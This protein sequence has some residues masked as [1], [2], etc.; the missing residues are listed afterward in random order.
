MAGAAGGGGAAVA[1]AGTGVGVA[2]ASVGGMVAGGAVAGTEGS[3]VAVG[4]RPP[5]SAMRRTATT[6]TARTVTRAK[7]RAGLSGEE[8]LLPP[9]GAGLA[10]LV[11]SPASL[12]ILSSSSDSQR[13]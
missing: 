3:G 12:A 2:G 7:D 4:S 10:P 13:P 11:L 1:G 9:L 5:G 8:G 6:T